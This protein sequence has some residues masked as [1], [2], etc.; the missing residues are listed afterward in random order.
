MGNLPTV[1]DGCAK[2]RD[3]ATRSSSRTE[4]HPAQ[5]SLPLPLELPLTAVWSISLVDALK[6]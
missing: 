3:D 4:P 6:S 5:P 2:R 1:G